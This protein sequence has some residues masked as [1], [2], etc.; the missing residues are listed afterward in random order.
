M[1]VIQDL[2]PLFCDPVVLVL[3]H[4]CAPRARGWQV[5]PGVLDA[6]PDAGLRGYSG[7]TRFFGLM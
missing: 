5:Q 7:D 6:G 1:E 3:R 2:T 4:R